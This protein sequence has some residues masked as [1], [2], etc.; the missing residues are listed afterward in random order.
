MEQLA[1]IAQNSVMAHSLEAA[2][3]FAK[4]RNWYLGGNAPAPPLGPAGERMIRREQLRM[5]WRMLE[6]VRMTDLPREDRTCGI[7]RKKIGQ[8]LPRDDGE[9]VHAIEHIELPVRLPCN[10]IYGRSCIETWLT[11]EGLRPACPWGCGG[12][13]EEIGRR[14]KIALEDS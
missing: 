9:E 5:V 4:L 10:H 2:A 12:L 3:L 14:A 13:S 1:W 7:C 11:R 8:P 6:P